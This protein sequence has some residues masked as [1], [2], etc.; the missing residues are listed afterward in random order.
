MARPSKHLYSSNSI[1]S[2]LFSNTP[3]W[4]PPQ[5]F[6]ISICVSPAAKWNALRSRTPQVIG[7]VRDKYMFKARPKALIT[8]P[9]G[10]GRPK[11]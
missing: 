1:T 8:K 4:T 9:A 7:V 3:V 6:A 2:P 11:S 10:D 5:R